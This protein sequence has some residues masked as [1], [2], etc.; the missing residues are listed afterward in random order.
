M[1]S[2]PGGWKTANAGEWWKRFVCR[3]VC[4]CVCLVAIAIACVAASPPA[5]AQV[6]AQDAC[7]LDF[8]NDGVVSLADLRDFEAVFG[9]DACPTGNCDD[10][11]FNGDGSRFDPADVDAYRAAYGGGPCPNGYYATPRWEGQVRVYLSSDGDDAND[12]RTRASAVATSQRA[13]AIVQD[14]VTR[15]RPWAVLIPRGTSVASLRGEY[16]AWAHGGSGGKPGYIAADPDDNPSLPRPRIVSAGGGGILLYAGNVRLIGLHFTNPSIARGQRGDGVK[17]Y[18]SGLQGRGHIVIDDCLV[19]QFG[20][21]LALQGED[22]TPPIGPFDVRNSAFIG[23]WSEDG[24]AQGTFVSNITDATFLRCVWYANGYNALRGVPATI[25]NHNVYAVPNCIRLRFIDCVSGYASAT[26]F[27]LRGLDMELRDSVSFNDP[28]SM[29]TGHAM[30]LPTQGFRGRVEDN[31]VIGGGR[32]NRDRIGGF[33]ALPRGFALGLNR[34]EGTAMRRNIVWREA[35]ESLD[36]QEGSAFWLQGGNVA[37]DVSDNLVFDARLSPACVPDVAA[38][39]AA[40]WCSAAVRDDR[41]AGTLP[42]FPRVGNRFVASHAG[43]PWEQ[44]PP[45]L[46]DYLNERGINVFDASMA[47]AAFCVE[48]SRN[49]RGAWNDAWTGRAINRW[50]RA[51]LQPAE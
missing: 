28:L 37:W 39:A 43:Q 16:G 24:H 18:G 17:V 3:L 31:L 49:R 41:A 27:Q 12:G 46:T 19:E 50:W 47:G 29:T 21:N 33:P 38:A 45:R 22:G 10:I 1:R 34:A 40:G 44:S 11:D 20:G 8:N 6:L 26:G 36:A 42:V 9:E 23:A 51:K 15:N 4:R 7:D 35:P 2:G 14:A 48:A 25:F 30:A 13:Y 32:I 5:S